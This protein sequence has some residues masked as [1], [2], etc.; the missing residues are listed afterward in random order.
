MYK[1]L[2]DNNKNQFYPLID[3][4]SIVNVNTIND[5][6][7]DGL[8]NPMVEDI[9]IEDE[10]HFDT[11]PYPRDSIV[12][13]YIPERA[14]KQA[15]LDV[16]TSNPECCIAAPADQ[17]TIT[18]WAKSKGESTITITE[19]NSG[20]SKEAKVFIQGCPSLDVRGSGPLNVSSDKLQ[21]SSD[22]AVYRVEA[23]S[24][25]SGYQ[26]SRWSDGNTENPRE[27]TIYKD[28]EL[29]AYYKPTLYKVEVRSSNNDWGTV[30]GG[31][32]VRYGSQI[33]IRAIPN[34]GYRFVQWSNGWTDPE[35]WVDVYNDEVFEAIFEEF[36]PNQDIYYTSNDGQVVQPLSDNFGANLVEN[37]YTNGQGVMK[38]DGD[39]TSIGDNAFMDCSSLTSIII[40]DS[41]THI[42]CA[43]SNCTSL[44]NITIPKELSSLG[45]YAFSGC[46]ALHTIIWNATHCNNIGGLNSMMGYQIDQDTAEHITTFIIGNSVEVLPYQIC[47]SM[48]IKDIVIPNNVQMI[49]AKA[50]SSCK[51]LT[52]V[53]IGNGVKNIG[54][55][56]FYDC[57]SLTSIAIPNGV[58]SIG[59][60]TFMG[61]SSLTSVVIPDSV[62]SIGNNAF[63][64][65]SSLTTVTIPESVTS[66]GNATFLECTSLTSI[67]IGNNV[68]DIASMTFAC[69]GLTEITSLN[70]IPPTI[71]SDTFQNVDK[72]IP[73]YVPDIEAYQNAEYWNEFTN[74]QT[75]SNYELIVNSSD[76]NMGTV[77]VDIHNAY[78]SSVT[79]TPN[80]GYR[81]VSWTNNGEIVSTESTYK[82][83]ASEDL[84]L[85]ANFEAIPQYTITVTYDDTM[86]TV[87]GQGTYQE[88]TQIELT[89]TP[90]EGYS[91]T[92]WS[93]GSTES[94]RQLTITS[95][96]E[97]MALF[98][99]KM[100]TVNVTVTEGG[101]VTGSGVYPYGSEITIEAI[102]EEGYE[103]YS[104][105]D[106]NQN[107]SI[108]MNIFA[109]LYI[110]AIFND[111]S[112]KVI[113]Y[114]TTD[115]NTLI[116][117][118]SNGFGSNLIDNQYN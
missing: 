111:A 69:N 44:T 112:G 38:F 59:E 48:S 79:A 67:T 97:L 57:S 45:A 11:A 68:T 72:S 51:S 64:A 27:I 36:N 46:D 32:S 4:K 113:Y 88:G 86:G 66:I 53:T 83:V 50:F 35:T 118:S 104:W 5:P 43:F 7:L 10:Y 115:E 62:T 6:Q 20:I 85:V 55:Y 12:V 1:Y 52:S 92:G 40:P 49:E 9:L 98:E 3:D 76:E 71:Q 22:E 16:T 82:F 17:N 31:G 25:D 105:S 103:F 91:F 37:T 114:T 106:G 58:T 84:A 14:G 19:A 8:F 18:L 15:Y 73:L 34:R 117:S 102:P 33:T 74:I 60:G 87:S 94:I 2:L 42:G 109:N 30:Q 75:Q 24:Y 89:A 116:P 29:T 54:N 81:F 41:V 108:T 77:Q 99:I 100:C 90:N 80:E 78:Q 26:F 56:A 39:V 95:D 70:P 63:R 47:Y 13:K 110:A 61:C 65:C 21:E 107:S 96:I 23:W 93:D 101:T 28:T